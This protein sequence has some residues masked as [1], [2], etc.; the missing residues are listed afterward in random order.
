MSNGYSFFLRYWSLLVAFLIVVLEIYARGIPIE[1]VEFENPAKVVWIM[2]L[3]IA[4]ATV[5]CLGLIVHS[6]QMQ[7]RYA[8]NKWRLVFWI[9]VVSF[10]ALC[11]IILG[12]RTIQIATYDLAIVYEQFQNL[13][14]YAGD[15]KDHLI[16]LVPLDI[17]L[18]LVWA[19]V[20]A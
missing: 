13:H 6:W 15:V 14:W 16:W 20:A 18:I 12:L 3:I 8:K 19:V 10:P 2:C 4:T 5:L 9:H 7:R 1:P 11:T 17:I